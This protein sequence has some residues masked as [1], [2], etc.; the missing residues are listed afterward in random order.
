MQYKI[1]AYIDAFSPR[2]VIGSTTIYRETGA[3]RLGACI[4]CR[5]STIVPKAKAAWSMAL[6]WV[7]HPTAYAILKGEGAMSVAGIKRVHAE[8]PV[9]HSDQQYYL[10]LVI[11]RWPKIMNESTVA[12]YVEQRYITR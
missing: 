12:E 2:R 1:C 9:S 3:V 4:R 5:N 10:A 7:N 6:S 11:T 8:D